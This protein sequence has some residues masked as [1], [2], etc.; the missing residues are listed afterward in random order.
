MVSIINNFYSHSKILFPYIR[1]RSS[2]LMLASILTI[3]DNMK[4]LL[5][6]LLLMPF[7]LSGA[8]LYVALD[9]S[10]AYSSIQSAVNAAADQDTILIY[11]GTY[12]ENIEIIGRNLS[13]GSLEFTT[14]D[15]TYIAQ[16]VIDAN[17][18][19][20]CFNITEDSEITLQGLYLTNGIGTPSFNWGDRKG[21]AVCVSES[22]INIINCRLIGNEAWTGA[23]VY[24]LHSFAYLAGTVITDNWEKC[25]GALTFAGYSLDGPRTLEF[26]PINRCSIYNNIAGSCGNDITIISQFYNSIDIYLDKATVAA[27][28]PYL[29][30]CI[31]TEQ[32]DTDQEF[33]YN[34]FINEA[35][36][37]QQFADLY[38][39]SEG[40][41]SNS[42][43]TPQTAL[44]TIALGADWDQNA[45]YNNYCPYDD[46]NLGRSVVGCTATATS[47]I[48]NYHKYWDHT[49]SAADGY[50]SIYHGFTT[51]IDGS[52][53]D[54]DF[55]NFNI[56]NNYMNAV[57]NKFNNNSP[58]NSND[59]AALC[60]AA[61]IMDRTNYS[62]LASG[63]NSYDAQ[64]AYINLNYNSQLLSRSSYSPRFESCTFTNNAAANGNGGGAPQ[65]PDYFQFNNN[66]LLNLTSSGLVLFKGSNYTIE[67]NI[68]HNCSPYD[69][70]WGGHSGNPNHATESLTINNCFFNDLNNH[71]DTQ[72]NTYQVFSISNPV[73]ATDPQLDS[74]YHPLWTASIM[75]PCIDSGHGTDEDD[76]PADI[77]AYPAVNHVCDVY[78]MPTNGTPKWMSFPVLNRITQEYDLA[79][80]FFAPIIS[81]DI[82][83]QVIWKDRNYLPTFMH[84]IEGLLLNGNTPV[85]SVLGYK[86]NLQSGV[87]QAL[88][89]PTSGFIQSPNT[90][91]NLYAHPA[92]SSTGVNENWIGYFLL[93]SS[94]PFTALASILDKVTSI[95]TQY[96][97]AIKGNG[98]WKVSS[99]NLTLNYG[100][101]VIITVSEDCSFAW[102]NEYPVDPKLRSKATAFEYVEKLDYT[103]M[104]IDLSGFDVLPSE[105]GL[106]VNGEC[107]GAVKV[108]GNYTDLCAYLDKY[109][110]I[111][112]ED[113]ELVLY[114]DT[115]AMENVKQ[116]CQLDSNDVKLSNEF[117]IRHYEIAINA[118]TDISPIISKNALSPNYPNP[119]NPETTI[120]YEIASDGNARIDIF[121]LKGQLVKTLVNDNKV[122]GPH[123]VVWNGTDKYGRKVAS[124]IYQY[125]L[126]TKDGS[127]T[128]K[129]I[130][131]K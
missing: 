79:E 100:D 99:A 22:N 39:S 78:T 42:G 94:N 34:A 89:I 73:V 17:Q 57:V 63:A 97:S 104:F 118:E 26:D 53:A 35:V 46:V 124:G 93:H 60:F 109:E 92:G 27:N 31:Y 8:T 69:V 56:L 116:R 98:F 48:I 83:D 21:G 32:Y 10:Q 50:T 96:W 16:T 107:K 121:N 33:T 7:V 43:L 110:V 86:I 74:Y 59:K 90:V 101:M 123:R 18:S 5:M 30:E 19:G 2:K 4:T 12:Y 126:I 1:K 119:F 106:Y 36:T 20:S 14:A 112:P 130:L 108:E 87:T 103:S 52:S 61:G 3:K 9:G 47:L 38:V 91:I 80:N 49:L 15:S 64:V 76:T 68:F 45:P 11:P 23:G 72:G 131:M 13:I 65:N 54:D 117:G 44:K 115:K 28:S 128:K 102:G 129:M 6:V 125:R 24:L 77:G 122:S 88:E 66:T 55:P 70:E 41:D 67:N 84:Y 105:I 29:K 25:F 120:S 71:V 85:Q 95:K 75:S 127:I 82:L 111:N 51:N 81:S 37:Q 114:F 113:W 40:D 58:L 62:S